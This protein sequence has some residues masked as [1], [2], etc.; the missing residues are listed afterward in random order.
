VSVGGDGNKS[1]MFT[2]RTDIARYVT[3]VLTHFPPEH[4]ENRAFTIAGEMKVTPYLRC[5]GV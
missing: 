1:F 2:S 3:Y 5:S 4:L